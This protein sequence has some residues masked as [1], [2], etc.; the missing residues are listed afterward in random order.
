MI[1]AMGGAG[2]AV[3]GGVALVRRKS[4]ELSKA[5][6]LE[7]EECSAWRRSA[8]R[9]IRSLRDVLTEHG[10]QEPDGIDDQLG[11]RQRIHSGQAEN[12]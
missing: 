8:L 7:L 5:E 10:I 2:A 4:G 12:S 9:I 1:T 3:L 11:I 6:Q